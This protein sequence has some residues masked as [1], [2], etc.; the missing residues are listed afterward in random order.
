M[1]MYQ[2]SQRYNM[3]FQRVWWDSEEAMIGW[4]V[5]FE[6]QHLYFKVSCWLLHYSLQEFGI[7]MA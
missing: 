4:A 3:R 7:I 1:P 6:G 2:N 5:V